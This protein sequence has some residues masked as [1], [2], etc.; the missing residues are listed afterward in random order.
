MDA[1]EHLTT[2]TKKYIKLISWTTLFDEP[3]ASLF[4]NLEKFLD[5]HLEEIPKVS[6][7]EIPKVSEEEIPQEG[8]V[9]DFIE[10]YKLFVTILSSYLR[11]INK[12]IKDSHKIINDYFE[13]VNLINNESVNHTNNESV[14]HTINEAKQ[15]YIEALQIKTNDLDNLSRYLYIFKNTSGL[16]ISNYYNQKISKFDLNHLELIQKF[17][18]LKEQ[19]LK[20][21]DLEIDNEIKHCFNEM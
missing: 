15:R 8:F 7:E 19:A 21:F 1:L 20:E 17:R 5:S 11:E 6:E 18:I 10:R 16:I 13:S 2:L 9:A 4:D 3:D 12:K 14:N